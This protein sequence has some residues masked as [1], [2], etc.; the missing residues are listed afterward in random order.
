MK[1]MCSINHFAIALFFSC[2]SCKNTCYRCMAMNQFIIF[3]ID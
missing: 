3:I 1:T 2:Y